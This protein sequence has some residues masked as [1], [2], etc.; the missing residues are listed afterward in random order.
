M[1]I[2]SFINMKGGV[3]KTTLTFN[4][5]WYSAALQ[6]PVL[7]VLLIDLDPQANLSQYF[8]G[9]TGYLDY[10]NNNLGTVVD[11]FNILPNPLSVIHQGFEWESGSKLHII[12]S[13]LELSS[14]LKNPYTRELVLSQYLSRIS[15]W[16]DLVLIDCAPTESV[17]TAAAYCASGYIVV[18]VKPEFLA[19]IGF[20]LLTRSLADHTQK[21]PNQE[22]EILGVVFNDMVRSNIPPEQMK[23]YYEVREYAARNN[24]PVF[25]NVAFSSASYPAGSRESTP[26]FNTPH[27]R[28]YVKRELYDVGD[29]FLSSIGLL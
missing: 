12:P 28:G 10:I 3:G 29:E 8:I 11:I 26:I 20:P 24:W 9:Q 22:L 5:G 14:V 1:K 16:Y 17:L 13:R 18:P 21:H 2:I 7:K 19:A 27:A 4:L 25:D 6:K 23:S 15:A